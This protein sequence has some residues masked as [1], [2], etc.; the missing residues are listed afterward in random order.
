MKTPTQKITF[1]TNF[2]GLDI[3]EGSLTEL[4]EIYKKSLVDQEG[5]LLEKGIIQFNRMSGIFN[6]L[7][8]KEHA[9]F[10]LIPTSLMNNVDAQIRGTLFFVLLLFPQNT[11]FCHLTF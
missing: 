10:E 9:M 1:L 6:F 11:N 5:Y 4:F 3:S 7:A 2:S 8:D